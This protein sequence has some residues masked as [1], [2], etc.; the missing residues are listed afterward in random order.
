MDSMQTDVDRE[1]LLIVRSTGV[2]GAY[3]RAFRKTDLE[4]RSCPTRLLGEKVSAT[5]TPKGGDDD[6]TS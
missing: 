6:A 4:R 1:E 2:K 5:P 3:I